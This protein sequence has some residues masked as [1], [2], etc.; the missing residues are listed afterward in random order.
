[1][2]IDIDHPIGDPD[3]PSFRHPV[4]Q[5]IADDLAMVNDCWENLRNSVDK[6]LPQEAAEP[7]DAYQQRL[8]WAVYTGFFREAIN[9]FA[10]VLSRFQLQDP[11]QTFEEYEDDIDLE[12]NS[13]HAF[14]AAADALLLRDGAVAIMVEM[15]PGQEATRADELAAGRRPYLTLQQRSMVLN[16]STQVMA[17]VEVPRHVTVLEMVEV[18]E[19][20]YGITVEPRYRVHGPGWWKLLRVERTNGGQVQV[21]E[22][23]SGEYLDSR[24]QP[25]PFPPVV[26]YSADRN[27]FGKGR[28]P[29]RQLALLSIE[30]MRQRCDLMMKTHKCALPVAVREGEPMPGPGQRAR[31]LVIGPNTAV[32]VPAGGKFY[33]AEPSAQSLAEQRAQI[34]HT[35]ELMQQQTLAF[36]Q[37][38]GNAKTATQAGLEAAQT[39]ASLQGMVQ[40]K[41][42]VLQRILAI[43]C[44]YTGEPLQPDA[45]IAMAASL[46][47][48]AMEAPD[49]AQLSAM[50]QNSQISTR[51]FL[52]QIIKGG[53][54]SV[55]T[56]AEEEMERLEEEAELRTEQIEASGPPVP[57]ADDLAE[58]IDLPGSDVIT[59]QAAEDER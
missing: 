50:E 42:N 53:V 46:Y 7:D 9:G 10:G 22:E 23:E 29:L 3:L 38:A 15:P 59:E 18:P 57:V 43:W 54:L 36:V 28:M 12:G 5:E 49:L 44:L 52:E 45:G 51:S 35:E 58:E 4:L 1:M 27:G 13:V 2:Q 14:M 8:S 41:M 17:G 26:W 39:Q 33:F 32:D 34:L 31:P 6:Y 37:G 56:S 25:L 19:G 47:D 16:W 48:R 30:H 24:R 20:E 11:P 40:Q 55:V 21:I